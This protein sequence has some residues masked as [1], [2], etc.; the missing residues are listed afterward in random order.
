MKETFKNFIFRMCKLAHIILTITSF[1]LCSHFYYGDIDAQGMRFLSHLFIYTVVLILS[2]RT[3]NAYDIGLSRPAILIYSQELSELVASGI[4]YVLMVLEKMVLINPLPLLGLLL[5]QFLL[6]CLW[7]SLAYRLY[8][9]FNKPRKSILL[10]RNDFDLQRLSEVQQHKKKFHVEKK[11]KVTSDNIHEIIKEIE[12]YEAVFV[13]GVNAA[14]RNGIVKHCVEENIRCY[15]APHVGD[16]I[17]MGAKHLELFNVPIFRVM[18][19]S[20]NFEYMALKRAFDIFCSFIGIVVLSPLMLFVAAAIRLQDGGPAF[21]KQ[22]RLTKDGKIFEIYKF[23]SMRVNAESDG[24]ARLSNEN[25]DRITPVGKVIRACRFDELP[26]LFNILKGDMSIV[27]PRPERP[28]IAKQYEETIPAF[29][30]RLQVRAGLTGLAQVYGRYNT[31]PYDKLQMDLMY[32]NNMSVVEDLKL[33]FATVKILFM[34]ESAQGTTHGQTTAM[35]RE[36]AN[37]QTSM[38]T[39]R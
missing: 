27:G 37:E 6:N 13:A 4:L 26:Q 34:K 20:P 17:L 1:A 22:R 19:A 23:R 31:D 32:I 10:Y 24:V 15:I 14:L 39:V 28:E 25:D 29:A 12:G 16:V 5:V 33:M 2:L 36:P 3:Y 8:F 38:K 11:I 30:L 21:Y 18:R 9:H 7:S 35:Y